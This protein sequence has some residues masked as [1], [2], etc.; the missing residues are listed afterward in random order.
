MARDRIDLRI[1]AVE[2][3]RPKVFISYAH[4]REIDGHRE[5]ALELAQALRMRG[6][7]ANID[8][9]FEH[10]PPFWPRWMSDEIRHADFVLCLASPAYKERVELH[11]DATIGRGAR[12]EGAIITEELYQD[13]ASAGSRF[14][15]VLLKGCS[16]DDI[17]DVLLSV[18]R[19]FYEWPRDDEDL[20]RRLTRQPRVLPEPLG[21]IVKL[22]TTASRHRRARQAD[23]GPADSD[24]RMPKSAS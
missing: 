19:S 6:V 20:Y 15:A 11:G 8:Q 3:T 10:D 14:I 22:E 24:E 2:M 18:G 7:E 9:F 23:G 12:W 17:P 1:P 16:A 21:E 5:R 4:E 13:T